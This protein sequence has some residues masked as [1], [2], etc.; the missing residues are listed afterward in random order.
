MA[1]A[2]CTGS[3][4]PFL[5]RIYSGPSEAADPIEDA[6]ADG[7]HGRALGPGGGARSE[8]GSTT[9]A[10]VTLR[11]W[12]N[13]NASNVRFEM[14]APT[15]G[16]VSVGW[17]ASFGGMIGSDA[18]YGWVSDANTSAAFASDA[19]LGAYSFGCPNGVCADAE[20]PGGQNNAQLL[21]AS[22]S[23]G[24]RNSCPGECRPSWS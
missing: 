6:D 16:W 2:P 12:V 4:C 13:R 18:V 15:T 8:D 24:G 3:G 23:G 11:W 14:S 9:V 22:Q 5:S 20:R 21:S 10:G 7:G 1:P 19:Y 17:S